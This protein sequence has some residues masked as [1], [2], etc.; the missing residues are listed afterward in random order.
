M[1]GP[2]VAVPFKLAMRTEGDWWVGYFQLINDPN[3]KVEL[4]RIRMASA[5]DEAIKTAFMEVMRLAVV[6]AMKAIGVPVVG[7]GGVEKAPESERSGRA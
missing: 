1:K 7:W 3:G 6:D 4:G 2:N 5:H